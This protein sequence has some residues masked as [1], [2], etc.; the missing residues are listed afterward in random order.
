VAREACRA[1]D[2][3]FDAALADA[4]VDL[5]YLAAATP[6][7]AGP[8]AL[9]LGPEALLHGD[10]RGLWTIFALQADSAVERQGLTRY[11]WRSEI[12][13]GAA[14]LVEPLTILSQGALDFAT[15]SPPVSDDAVATRN[16]PLIELGIATGLG[17]S[18]REAAL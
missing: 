18:P 8:C 3:D 16:F 9:W 5:L 11:R 10:D 1:E 12:A 7:H 2:L 17:L 4:A 15:R 6:P 13:P 14:S